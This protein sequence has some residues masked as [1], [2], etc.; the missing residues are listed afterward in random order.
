MVVIRGVAGRSDQI[1]HKVNETY[2][3]IT[4]SMMRIEVT[5]KMVIKYILMRIIS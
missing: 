1:Y 4:L 2:I 5:M 3:R